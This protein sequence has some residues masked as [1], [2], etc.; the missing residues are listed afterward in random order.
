[1]SE[2]EIAVD[3][4]TAVTGL[5]NPSTSF[6]SVVN[7]PVQKA[8]WYYALVFCSKLSMQEGLTPVY[9]I[10]GSTDP[11]VWEVVP[12]TSNATTCNAAATNWSTTGYRLPT[13]MAWEWTAMGATD[14]RTN[15][16][17]G[18]TGSNTIGNYTW[19]SGNAGSTTH[20]VG[21]ETANE[22]G[23]FDMSG[24]VFEWCSDWYAASYP[25]GAL[26]SDSDAGRGAAS[27]MYRVRRGGS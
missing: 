26:T 14:S 22:L 5:A 25:A 6:T 16:F 3:Q 20:P 9:T 2:K 8:T 24:N 19:Y 21:T 15:A 4:F 13:E 23:L 1:M 18:S 17:A 7:G 27:G 11:A 10:N 12:T